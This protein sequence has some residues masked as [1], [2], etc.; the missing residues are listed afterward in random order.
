VT[1][2]VRIV[3]SAILALAIVACQPGTIT[4]PVP[5]VPQIGADLHCASGDHGYEDN[6]AGWGFCYPGTWKYTLKS[7]F[8][9]NPQE[10][11]LTFDITNVP[12]ASAAP[13]ERPTCSAGAGLYAFMIVS[14]YPRG[15]SADLAS[16]VQANIASKPTLQPIDWGNATQAA[17]MSDARRI[18]LTPHQVVILDLRSGPGLLDLETAMSSRLGTWK[19]SY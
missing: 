14:T 4:H 16:W 3:T 10:L 15:D 19:F 7:Q 18:A 2:T 6:Q 11:D 8:Y 13:N 12:C 5:S 17:Q 9:P 1:A